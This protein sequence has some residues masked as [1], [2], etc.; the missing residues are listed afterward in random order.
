VH[1]A[2][3]K[4]TTSTA[5]H[6]HAWLQVAP[7]H[8]GI[9]LG[10]GDA[11]LLKALANATGRSDAQLRKE[12]Q[13]AGDLGEVAAKSKGRQRTMFQPKPLTIRVRASAKPAFL[14]TQCFSH[15]ARAHLV[16]CT[17][18]ADCSLQLPLALCGTSSCGQRIH[19]LTHCRAS[20]SS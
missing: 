11:I 9:E 3:T 10:I 14:W 2:M 18:R 4:T 12:F 7:A 6:G 16:R 15:S 1:N 19:M 13:E 5:D 17:A 8:A 20:S